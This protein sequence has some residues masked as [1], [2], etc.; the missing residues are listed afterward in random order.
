M[1]TVRVVD[2]SAFSVNIQDQGY[3]GLIG[4]GP[5]TGSKIRAYIDDPSGDSVM[6]RIFLANNS[7]SNY[8]TLLLNRQGSPTV[9]P[10]GQMTIS[11]ILPQY[12]NITSMPKL[13]VGKVHKLTDRD[14]HW[15]VLTDAK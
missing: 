6:N 8:M 13:T 14:Q 15:Q 4:L 2:T 7:A 10:T 1:V 5:N 12:Q 11:E 9:Q 3:S